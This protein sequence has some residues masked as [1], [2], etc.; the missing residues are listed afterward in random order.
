[1]KHADLLTRLLPPVSYDSKGDIL[2]AE[3]NAEGNALDVTAQSAQ[4]V[5]NGVTPFYAADLLTDWERVCGLTST[6]ADSYQHRLEMVLLKLAETGGLSIPY[7]INLAKKMG[8]TIEIVEF[9]PFRAGRDCA[10]MQLWEPGIIW[11]WQVVVKGSAGLISYSFR[12]G[13]SCAGERLLDFSDPIIEAV[14][15]DLKPAHTYCYFSYV[16]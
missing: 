6:Q 16:E 1:M 5:N 9:D 12:A 14:F 2:T 8:Y 4:R 15:E 10:G 13:A 3:L 11:V 7:F